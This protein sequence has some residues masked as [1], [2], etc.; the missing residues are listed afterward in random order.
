MYDQLMFGADKPILQPWMM[1]MIQ[2]E[3]LV[4]EEREGLEVEL[5]TLCTSITND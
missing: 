4:Q 5:C 1:R 3:V 2:D